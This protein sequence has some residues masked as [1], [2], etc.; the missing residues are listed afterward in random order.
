MTTETFT[1]EI[2]GKHQCHVLSLGLIWCKD[3]HYPCNNDCVYREPDS[4]EVTVTS[5]STKDRDN[6]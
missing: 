2:W 4:Y 6:E 3:G 1:Q 5:T